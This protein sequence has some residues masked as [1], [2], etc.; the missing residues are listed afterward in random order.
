M[1]GDGGALDEPEN[2]SAPSLLRSTGPW[3]YLALSKP[4]RI[5]RRFCWR[6]VRL[7]EIGVQ[8]RCDSV[9]G[10]LAVNVEVAQI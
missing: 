8:R 5:S 2:P 7:V 1:S 4:E 9:S 10:F 3:G 6:R